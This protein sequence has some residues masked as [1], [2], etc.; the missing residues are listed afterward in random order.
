MG[1]SRFTAP[2]TFSHIS[3]FRCP[4]HLIQIPVQTTTRPFCG[5]L[6]HWRSSS[7][8]SPSIQCCATRIYRQH[9]RVAQAT[10]IRCFLRLVHP[11]PEPEPELE[12][13]VSSRSL[14]PRAR[15]FRLY[16]RH[17]I[18]LAVATDMGAPKAIRALVGPLWHIHFK[19]ILF[20]WVSFFAQES[21][22]HI[23]FD[24]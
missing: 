1:S 15:P 22:R 7:A 9:A 17:T 21:R 2:V 13:L 19:H 20:I 10:A 3:D 5:T 23:Y 8:P 4:K 18:V 6:P 14:L 24:L 12:A 11:E 16:F